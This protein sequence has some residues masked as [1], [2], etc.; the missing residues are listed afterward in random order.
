VDL[1]M[2]QPSPGLLA[3]SLP[4]TWL[5]IAGTR[6]AR[7]WS[8]LA[9]LRYVILAVYEKGSTEHAA[10]STRPRQRRTS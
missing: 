4:L 1:R 5:E 10:R 8:V 2:Y 7:R 9:P 3:F 6:L